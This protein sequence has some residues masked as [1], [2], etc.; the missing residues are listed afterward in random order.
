MLAEYS[1]WLMPV[2]AQ[3]ASLTNTVARLSGFLGGEVFAPHVT[4]Q[5]DLAMSPEELSRLVAALAERVT[6][7]IW[8]VQQVESSDHFF[9]CLY[10]RFGAEPGFEALQGAVRAFTQT[11]D[12]LSP[13]A[14]L[15]LAYG[16]A[17]AGHS[18]ARMDLLDEFALREIVFDRLA[19]SR[20]SKNLPIADWRC[21]VLYP[22]Q[23]PC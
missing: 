7:Q 23:H 21:M 1:I 6:V 22:L 14:H 5:G 18:K 13:F 15:S 11:D 20:S 10:L 9:R 3:Q 8:R 16:Q 2:A 17:G 19:I 4:I 12:G